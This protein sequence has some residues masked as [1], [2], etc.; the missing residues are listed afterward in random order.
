MTR[1]E[2]QKIKAVL[3]KIKN[4]DAFFREAIHLVETYI[5]IYNKRADENCK[6]HESGYD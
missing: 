3:E 2:L 5:E 4:K 1:K 6:N